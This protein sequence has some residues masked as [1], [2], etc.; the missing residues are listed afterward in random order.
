[1]SEDSAGLSDSPSPTS[2]RPH[3]H[4]S[5]RNS[6][7]GD[8]VPSL[9]QSLEIARIELL[10]GY[11]WVRH[12]D[13][14][15][16]FTI[17]V[18]VM[19]VFLLYQTFDAARAIGASLAAGGVMPAWLV[20]ATSVLWLFLTILLVG[21]ALGSN[22]DLDNDGQYLTIRPAADV[23]GGL[24]LAA[25][26][27]FS[28]YTI[29]LGLAAGA[30]LVAG[31]DSF[32]PILGIA[33]AAVGIPATAAAIGYPIGFTL[34]GFGRRSENV[35]RLVT[36]LGIGLGLAYITL[37]VTGE[38][39]TIVER[40][41]PVLQSP[42]MAWFGHLALATTPNAGVD[43]TGVLLLCGLMPIVVIGGTVL[44]VPA[45]RYAWL[46]D[47]PH[48]SES[49]EEALPTAPNTR[50]DAALDV[51]CRAPATRGIAS[52]TLRRAVRSPFQFVFVA[53]PLLAAILFVE[54]AVTTGTVPWYVPW[55]VVWYGAWASGAVLPLNPLGNQGAT[56]PTLLTAPAHGRHVVHGTIVA[57]A[58]VGAPLTAG[59]A[60]AAGYLAGS[61]PPV[62]V[63]LGV[64]SVTA[65]AA[66]A[67]VATGIGSVF[68]RFDAV[69]LDGSRRAVPPSKRAYSLFSTVL[70]LIVVAVAFAADETARTV[71]AVLLPRWLPGVSEIGAGTL[72]TLGWVVIVGGVAALPVAYRRAVR[73][74][75]T[76]R[77]Q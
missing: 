38:L 39:L 21:D 8:A 73:R 49:D 64:A 33:V 5:A 36:V 65:V 48:A 1:M 10:R 27:K 19:S 47:T 77:L 76:Y 18:G 53:P 14:W 34:K 69:N 61:S 42:P 75:E 59:V 24:L 68:P 45:A 3:S 9:G 23:V 32:S 72:E 54:S 6:T 71:G 50:L 20:T 74:L 17:L 28:V 25:A 31:T 30:G 4:G 22:G 60:L 62:L 12:Q 29:G 11:R 37:S 44:A 40:L 16:L 70:S 7:L 58:L 57:A 55:F 52:T 13:F 67:L 26:A 66:S 56:L 35:S 15:V 2:A 46:A 43:A 63:A 41:E 51:V